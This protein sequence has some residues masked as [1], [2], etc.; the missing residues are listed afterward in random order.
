MTENAESHESKLRRLEHIAR[1]LVGE[2]AAGGTP[3]MLDPD[4]DILLDRMEAL[5]EKLRSSRGGP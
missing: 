4:I 2:A 3:G 5:V 1:A